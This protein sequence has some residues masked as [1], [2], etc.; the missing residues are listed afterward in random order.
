MINKEDIEKLDLDP[1]D[2]VIFEL[3]ENTS[4]SKVESIKKIIRQVK[5]KTKI[6]NPF[7]LL[8]GKIE[9]DKLTEEQMNHHGWYKL[10]EE[11]KKKL[12]KS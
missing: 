7:V 10:S 4:Q 8:V 3:P 9:I 11:E 6:D 5:E 1:D 2:V 12:G